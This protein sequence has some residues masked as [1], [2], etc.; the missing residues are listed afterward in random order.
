M[1]SFTLCNHFCDSIE[2]I[3]CESSIIRKNKKDYILNISAV[4]DIET[5]SFYLGYG[6]DKHKCGCMYAWVFGINGKCIKGRTWQEFEDTI[7][8]VVEYY[9]LNLNKRLIIYVHNLGYEFQWIKHRFEW[10]KIFSVESRRPLYAI[11]TKGIE[12]R[13]S[14]LLSGLSLEKTGENLVYYK[15]QKMV[16]DLDYRKIRH[17]ET[18]LTDKEWGYIL[19]DGLVVMAFI[20]EEI[21]RLGNITNLPLTKT[22]YVRKLCVEKCLRGEDRFVY[23]KIMQ[24]LRISTSDYHELKRAYTGGFTHANHNYVGKICN[25]VS[26]FDFTSSY[27]TVML[28]EKYPMSLGYKVKIKDIEDFRIKLKRY[29]CMFDIT[30][31]NIEASVNFEHYI[32]SARC[33]ELEHYVLD[34]GRVVEASKLK[35]TVTEQDF[36]IIEQ[37]YTWE[38]I[39]ISN[40]VIFEKG[41]LPKTL[42]EVVL[43]LYSDKTTLKGIEGKEQEYLVSKGMLNSIYGMSVTDPCKDEI[44]YDNNND[45]YVEKADIDKLIDIYN[46]SRQ[47]CLY[48]PWGVWITAYARRNLFSG[49]LEF[50]D[51][52]VYSDTDSIKVINVDNHKEYIENYNKE[53]E[54]KIKKCLNTYGIPI[55]KAKPKTKEGVVK[56]LGIWDFEGTYTKFKTMGAK[57]YMYEKKNKIFITISGVSKVKGVEYLERIYGNNNAIFD[58]F[59]DGLVFPGEYEFKLPNEDEEKTFTGSGKLTHTYIDDYRCDYVID[60]LGNEGIFCEYSSIHMEPTTYEMGLDEAFKKYIQGETGVL[61]R[62]KN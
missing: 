22:G 14:Y 32:S 50:K 48:Y 29:C 54:Q 15:V 44:C 41:Y 11:T 1:S 34:N 43:K 51:D 16:G 55:S 20:Q 33:Q 56:P 52:Y 61:L 60:Y 3:L 8:R 23:Y 53:I 10:S 25:N 49:I 2:D 24:A 7:N 40:F 58:A 21:E 39:D 46:S 62:P 27:P 26:S 36:F 19:N 42:I 59:S 5:S 6:E 30:F 18:P 4:F 35:M 57:R 45:W 9:S 12:F 28:S 37:M 31:Y 38:Y 47:R 17:S 13:C